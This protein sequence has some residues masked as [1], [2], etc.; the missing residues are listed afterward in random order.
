VPYACAG[1][2]CLVPAKQSAVRRSI[3]TVVRRDTPLTLLEVFDAP[4]LQPN[5]LRRGYS[6]V[7]TQALQLLNGE[8]IREDARYFAGRV[9]DAA[10]EDLS[11]QVER[12]Y[13]MALSRP[14]TQQEAITGAEAIQSFTRQWL[15]QL[16]KEVPAEPRQAK[17]KWLGLAS[18]CHVMLNSPDFVYID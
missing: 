14:P 11:K 7:P 16:Q 15:E 8:M 4:Q 3:Y 1:G 5:C 18:F 10:G 13:W 9:I 2:V 12:A 17:A 6:T